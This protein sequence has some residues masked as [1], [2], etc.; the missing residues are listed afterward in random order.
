MSRLIVGGWVCAALLGCGGPVLETREP[1]PG[2]THFTA[3]S[4]NLNIEQAGNPA[5]LDAVGSADADVVC[6]Q[7]VNAQWQAEI[8]ERYASQYP[9]MVFAPKENAGGLGILSRWPIEP[10]VVIPD[11]ELHP[12]W[13]TRVEGPEGP[14]QLVNVHLRSLFNGDGNPVANFLETGDVHRAQIELFMGFTEPGLPTVVLGDF[15]EGV[16]GAAVRWLEEQ[17]YQNMLPLFRPGQYTWKA[18]TLGNQA[19]LAIDHVMIS[20]DLAPLSARVLDPGQSDHLPVWAHAEYREPRL[21][22]ADATAQN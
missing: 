22:P 1:T 5:T 12:T 7:E 8:E 4:F 16:N 9:H 19:D 15:N 10:G 21:L 20:A 14:I 2:H 11:G 3:V 17:G 18:P 6:L 13:V